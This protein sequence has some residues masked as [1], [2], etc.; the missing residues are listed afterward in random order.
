MCPQLGNSELHGAYSGPRR[1]DP[2]L[3]FVFFTVPYKQESAIRQPS[4]LKTTLSLTRPNFGC[5]LGAALEARAQCVYNKVEAWK[6][7]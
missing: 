7:A 2:S 5:K 6:R 1:Q 3:A 4:R